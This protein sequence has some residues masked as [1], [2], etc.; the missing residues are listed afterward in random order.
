MVDQIQS[1]LNHLPL[2][3]REG[4]LV[5]KILQV[6]G[7]QLAILEEDGR[8]VQRAHWFDQILE[9]GEAARLAAL[10]DILPESWQTL[11][12]Y[13]AWV[14]ALRNARLEYGAV[15]PQ[16]ITNFVQQ[17]TNDFLD[18]SEV[19]D[20]PAV[21]PIE[22]WMWMVGTTRKNSPGS[23]A[24]NTRQSDEGQALFL[25][26]PP[27]RRYDRVPIVG[28]IEPL[29]Q[30]SLVNKGLDEA[31][32]S[33]LLVGIPGAPESVPVVANLTSGQALIYLDNVPPGQRLFIH[34]TAEGVTASLEG[35]D[36]TANLRLVSGLQPGTPWESS[37][38]TS[39][40]DGTL[41]GQGLVLRRGRN[42]MWYL[43]VAHFDALGLDRFLLS[44]ADLLLQQ[45]R[46]D[47]TM[48]N[49]ALFYQDPA[50][51]LRLTWLETTPAGFEVSL[52][53][54]ALLHLPNRLTEALSELGHL[55]LSLNQAVQRLK[56]AGVQAAVKLT[57]FTETQGQLDRLQ[58]VLP[59]VQREVGPTGADAIP[60]SGG[61]FEVTRFEGS[62]FR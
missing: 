38:V 48:F 30:F 39:P 14:H 10:L 56:A 34:Q 60:E 16:A 8:E 45:G 11:G 47:Q 37:Q 51:L 17:Y 53:A 58:L 23:G 7:L 24:G 50:A 19:L 41:I 49:H 25:E 31:L 46:Y 42:D 4:E 29:T 54:G 20:I 18:A 13:R 52:P 12:E 27:H 21:Q 32:P 1:M 2:L 33:F 28:G 44:L 9:L 22:R 55:E 57:S 61:V 35:R 43:P 5:S 26:N 59:M 3:Y 6:P 15:T 62:T 40:V 36:V